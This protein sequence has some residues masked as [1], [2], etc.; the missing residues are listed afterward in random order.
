MVLTVQVIGFVMDD[1][2]GDMIYT[3]TMTLITGV[4]YGYNFNDSNGSGYESGSNLEGVCAGGSYGNDR[5]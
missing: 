5:N 3:Y 4:E 1:S 2:D